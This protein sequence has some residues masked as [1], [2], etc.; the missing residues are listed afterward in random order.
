MK[1]SPQISLVFVVIFGAAFVGGYRIWSNLSDE[2]DKP[3]LGG[4][5]RTMDE[6]NTVYGAG[7]MTHYDSG[8]KYQQITYSRWFAP[9]VIVDFLQGIAVQ[10]RYQGMSDTQMDRY[11][12]LNSQGR[13]WTLTHQN[14]NFN[15]PYYEWERDDGAVATYEARE[16]TIRAPALG[17]PRRE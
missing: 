16:M 12:D 9:D 3:E 5:G 11:L 7:E 14:T 13:K 10:V 2:P 6:L 8:E 17:K 4:L 15:G 1:S